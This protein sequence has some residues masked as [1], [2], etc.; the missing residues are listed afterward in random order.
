MFRFLSALKLS[1]RQPEK[2]VVEGTK[3]EV[4]CPPAGKIGVEVNKRR[5]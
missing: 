3:E 2:L 1:A 4:K 5:G